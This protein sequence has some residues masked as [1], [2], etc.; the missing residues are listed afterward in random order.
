MEL[1]EQA[2]AALTGPEQSAW[3][4]RLDRDHANFVAAL[5]WLEQADDGPRMLRLAAALWHYWFTN[6][7]H[8]EAREWLARALA[9]PGESAPVVRAKALRLAASLARLHQDF[10]VAEQLAAEGLELARKTADVPT[11]AGALSTAGNVAVR[12]GDLARARAVYEELLEIATASDFAR[13]RTNATL[14]LGS[15]ALL[16]G[17][18]ERA[19]EMSRA[20]VGLASALGDAETRAVSLFNL[21]CAQLEVGEARQAATAFADSTRLSLDGGFREQL[22]YCLVGVAAVAERRGDARGAG[23]LLG[24]ADVMLEEIGAALAPYERGLHART[25]TVVREAL[26][27]DADGAWSDGR[28]VLPEQTLEEALTRLA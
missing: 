7:Y 11:I 25:T 28:R 23:V 22:V 26:A 12:N 21:G 13:G 5:G 17:E 24:A 4:R 10:A 3:L 27:Q 16:E 9:A 1:A 18:A 19:I 6:G 15:L 2:E 20:A 14:N 8:T